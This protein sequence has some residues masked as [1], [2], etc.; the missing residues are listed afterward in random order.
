MLEERAFSLVELGRAREVLLTAASTFLKPVLALNGVPV[1]NGE[2]GPVAQ[3][4]FALFTRR[5]LAG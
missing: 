5:V 1:G 2:T 4:L 3:S